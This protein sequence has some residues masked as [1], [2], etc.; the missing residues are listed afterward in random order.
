MLV[1]SAEAEHELES[2]PGLCPGPASRHRQSIGEHGAS[3]GCV[4]WMSRVEE[5]L[6]PRAEVRVRR[7]VRPP[8]FA[9]ERIVCSQGSETSGPARGRTFIL[10]ATG[11]GANATGP[12]SDARGPV[13]AGRVIRRGLGFGRRRWDELRAPCAP[14]GLRHGTRMVRRRSMA[15]HRVPR[16]V[17]WARHALDAT[18]DLPARMC[19]SWGCPPSGKAESV[20]RARCLAGSTPHTWQPQ[21]ALRAGES[22]IRTIRSL[23][24]ILVASLRTSASDDIRS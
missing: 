3:A 7:L 12:L 17:A 11:P 24:G 8:C 10:A 23:L 22:C 5:R 19:W 18:W 2:A 15:D 14:G 13:T 20:A 4:E 1:V 9:R 6:R 16:S 21:H